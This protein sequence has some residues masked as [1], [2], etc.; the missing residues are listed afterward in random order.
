[1]E[2]FPQNLKSKIKTSRF[3]ISDLIDI[4]KQ[5]IASIYE[6]HKSGVVHRDIKAENIL[7]ESIDQVRLD[8]SDVERINVRISDFSSARSF[9]ENKKLTK[10]VGTVSSYS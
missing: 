9:N 8:N 1:M 4:L 6:L 2:Y 5:I 10:K 3:C 7:I